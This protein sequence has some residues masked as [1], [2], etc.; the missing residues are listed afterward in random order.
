MQTMFINEKSG[1]LSTPTDEQASVNTPKA[2][3]GTVSTTTSIIQPAQNGNTQNYNNSSNAAQGTVLCAVFASTC[4]CSWEGGS[5]SRG[6]FPLGNW[7]FLLENKG[8]SALHGQLRELSPVLPALSGH[9]LIREP[10]KTN[11]TKGPS[12]YVPCRE[13]FFPF[14]SIS[15]TF[16][17]QAVL[18]LTLILAVSTPYLL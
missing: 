5:L 16:Y 9:P 11:R 6:C 7:L 12:P 14:F 1:N 3:S 17:L 8:K 2:S 4:F 13:S 18:S 10:S 15:L